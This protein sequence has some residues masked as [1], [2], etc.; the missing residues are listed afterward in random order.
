MKY[1]V[2]VG[3]PIDG[4]E[5]YG[6]FDDDT[7]AEDWAE[8]YRRNDTWWVSELREPMRQGVGA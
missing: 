1:L 7:A 2:V 3:N 4:C 5:F 8:R 6:P